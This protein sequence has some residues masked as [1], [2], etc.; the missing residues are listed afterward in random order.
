VDRARISGKTDK[1]VFQP[2]GWIKT[3]DGPRTCVKYTGFQNPEAAHVVALETW[4]SKYV[5]PN[6]AVLCNDYA[7][8]LWKPVSVGSTGKD[9]TP[10]APSTPL[11]RKG[12][13]S[14][15][16]PVGEYSSP[17]TTPVKGMLCIFLK[18][19]YL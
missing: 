15:S 11:K 19:V 16:F 2:S 5:L 12:L 1:S 13:H 14:S 8:E 18:F 3:Q 4:N 10:V 7:V 17:N 6:G 9:S